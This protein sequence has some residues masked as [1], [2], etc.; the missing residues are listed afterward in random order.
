[1]VPSEDL[2]AWATTPANWDYTEKDTDFP[3]IS[4]QVVTDGFNFLCLPPPDKRD[5]AL[6]VSIDRQLCTSTF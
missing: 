1:M 4:S 3:L 2:S 5:G 6:Q